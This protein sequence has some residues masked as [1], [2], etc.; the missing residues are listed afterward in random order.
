MPS[1]Y[2]QIVLRHCTPLQ[3]GGTSTL[4][5]QAED[6]EVLRQFPPASLARLREQRRVLLK[7]AEQNPVSLPPFRRTG[8]LSGKVLTAT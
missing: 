1:V 2:S 3:W 4:A 5:A 8:K 7:Y 6:F